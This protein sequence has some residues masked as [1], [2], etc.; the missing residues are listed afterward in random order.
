MSFVY[1]VISA[2][3]CSDIG[4]NCR[5]GRNCSSPVARWQLIQVRQSRYRLFGCQRDAGQPRPVHLH[6]FQQP[7]QTLPVSA[8]EAVIRGELFMSRRAADQ[9]CHQSDQRRSC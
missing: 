4:N 3:L 7:G 1:A 2:A 8:A 6:H 5:A 9:Q